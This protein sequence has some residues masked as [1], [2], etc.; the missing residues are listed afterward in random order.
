MQGQRQMF[1]KL[2]ELLCRKS[3]QWEDL[4]SVTVPHLRS[5]YIILEA[6]NCCSS[7]QRDAHGA[8]IKKAKGADVTWV[9]EENESSKGQLDLASVLYAPD[10]RLA[11]TLWSPQPLCARES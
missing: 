3:S 6:K 2:T 11:T 1:A 4:N 8:V 9:D 7:D 5:L 10:W